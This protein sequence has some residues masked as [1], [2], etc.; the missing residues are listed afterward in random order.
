MS[1]QSPDLINIVEDDAVSVNDDLIGN[2]EVSSSSEQQATYVP[3]DPN[4][5][6]SRGYC[7]ICGP[8]KDIVEVVRKFSNVTPTKGDLKKKR[9]RIFK[10][11]QS[12]NQ[13]RRQMHGLKGQKETKLICPAGISGTLIW[14]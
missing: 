5:V 6:N 4:D 3:L 8:E 11:R 10:T 14:I 12:F 13:H 2:E 9:D 7:S 1:A